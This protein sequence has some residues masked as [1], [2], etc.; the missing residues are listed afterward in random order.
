MYININD[1]NK[2]VVVCTNYNVFHKNS[3]AGKRGPDYD[4]ESY[5][6]INHKLII[7]CTNCIVFHKI[8]NKIS[9]IGLIM[10]LH[11]KIVKHLYY[12][13]HFDFV[14]VTAK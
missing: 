11:N 7:V 3:E 12:Y 9:P 5:T 2:L 1:Y 8:F 6:N 14:F 10:P 13:I 4:F